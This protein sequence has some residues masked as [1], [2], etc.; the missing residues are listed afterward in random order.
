MLIL[1]TGGAGFIGSHLVR[2]LLAAGHT[3]RVLDNLSSGKRGNLPAD[4]RL[5][6]VEGDI[7]DVSHLNPAV[8]GVEAI[9]HLAAVASVQ[10]SAD[11]PVG[12]HGSNFMGTLNLLEAARRHRVRR[13]IYASSA[14]VYGD[15][16]ALPVREDTS[17]RP[18]TPYASDKLAGEHYLA[19]YARK[20]DIKE[21]AFRFFNIYGPRQ[22]PSSPYSGVISIFVDKARKGHPITVFGD[23]FQ[24]RD[25]V[26]VSDL[27]EIL[28]RT[29]ERQ[30]TAGQI[31][32][33]GR[34]VECSLLD[35]L[36]ELERLMGKPIERRFEAPRIGDIRN[37]RADVARLTTFLDYVPSTPIGVGLKELLQ[38]RD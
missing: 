2:R 3:I 32:N 29:L 25:F 38:Y 6:F 27:V 20:Y 17:L 33:V 36:D 13:F 18:L 5:E 16:A 30:S 14:A 7:R 28:Y 1:I 22:D 34:G 9:F 31:M 37:S 21:T 15:S 35:L 26:Y 12:T 19:F 24:S 4:K 10:A 11:D 8:S 23:G